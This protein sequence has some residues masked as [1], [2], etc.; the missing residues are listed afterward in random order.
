M[1][2]QVIH[3]PHNATNCCN[4]A[5]HKAQNVVSNNNNLINR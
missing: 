3:V 5:V 4:N 1:A 2:F